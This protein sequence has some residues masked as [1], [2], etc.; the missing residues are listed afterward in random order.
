IISSKRRPSAAP[1]GANCL[2]LPMPHPPAGYYVAGGRGFSGERHWRVEPAQKRQ[3]MVPPYTIRM[4]KQRQHTS[5]RTPR[6]PQREGPATTPP[7]RDA[8]AEAGVERL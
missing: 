6:L 4:E 2:L 8:E 3:A 7:A 5:G 1:N